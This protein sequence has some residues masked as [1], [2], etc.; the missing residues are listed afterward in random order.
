MPVNSNGEPVSSVTIN[1]TEGVGT[2]FS[3]GT[4]NYTLED[5]GKTFLYTI[6]ESGNVKDVKNDKPITIKVTVTDNGDG[7]LSVSQDKSGTGLIFTNKYV[8]GSDA[9]V[10]TGDSMNMGALL[11]MIL[12]GI[13]LLLLLFRRRRSQDE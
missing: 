4:I 11:L 3:F 6:T 7:T 2:S 9:G 13:G 12:S 8:P 10:L 1:P 5:A